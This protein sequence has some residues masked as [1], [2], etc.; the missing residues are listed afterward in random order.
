MHQLTLKS[1]GT[2]DVALTRNAL[3]M[4]GKAFGE[5]AAVG[6]MI[7][8]YLA[9][10]AQEAYFLGIVTEEKVIQMQ[11][12]HIYTNTFQIGRTHVYNFSLN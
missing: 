11:C 3:S 12:L 5:E 1:G 4:E 10:G 9:Y 6:E 8:V 7:A 2:A